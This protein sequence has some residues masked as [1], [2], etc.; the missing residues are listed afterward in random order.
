MIVLYFIF[1]VLQQY[2]LNAKARSIIF[3]NIA[4]HLAFRK[5]Y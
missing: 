4:S 3:I 2:F 5:Y 1:T